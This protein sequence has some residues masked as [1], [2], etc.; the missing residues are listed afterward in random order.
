MKKLIF[1]RENPGQN[2]LPS[3]Q[4]WPVSYSQF[5]HLQN[6]TIEAFSS[7]VKGLVGEVESDEVIQL[8]G[9]EISESAGTYSMSEGILFFGNEIYVCPAVSVVPTGSQKIV[10]KVFQEDLVKMVYG[11]KES[12]GARSTD[13]LSLVAE[14]SDDNTFTEYNP[15]KVKTL[16]EKLYTK[17]DIQARIQEAVDTVLGGVS[18]DLNSLSKI[19]ETLNSADGALQLAD[20]SYKLRDG[21]VGNH[22][23]NDEI[24]IGDLGELNTDNKESLVEA[25]NELNSKIQQSMDEIRGGIAPELDT[26]SKMH[27]AMLEGNLEFNDGSRYDLK[28]GV[29]SNDHLQTSVKVGDLDDLKTTN[30]LDVISSINELFD[31]VGSI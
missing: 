5:E 11:D 9:A 3:S 25:I 30:K 14:A 1:H 31:V 18:D 17:L 2:D 12:Y 10:W 27:E 7:M 4:G 21:V 29:I 19:T 16:K 26:L 28:Y 23:L 15:E 8:H 20:G 13:I 24:K 6:G 22:N